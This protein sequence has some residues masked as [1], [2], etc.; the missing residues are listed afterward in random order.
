MENTNK[1]ESL[2]SFLSLYISIFLRIYTYILF[3]N[4]I[5]KK[6]NA[7]QK[8]LK[9]LRILSVLILLP[10]FTNC[11]L[12]DSNTPSTEKINS[13]QSRA[14]NNYN[15][16]LF[17]QP[18]SPLVNGTIFQTELQLNTDATSNAITLPFAFS[19]YGE[20]MSTVYLSNNGFIGFG[21]APNRTT[22]YNAISSSETLAKYLISFSNQITAWNGE[23]SQP[24]ISYGQNFLGDMVFQFKDVSIQTAPQ[25]RMTFQFIL[26]SNGSTVQIVFG[27][28]CTGQDQISNTSPRIFE[29]GLRGL[30][31]APS[32]NPT[33]IFKQT[34]AGGYHNRLLISGNWNTLSNV[35]AGTQPSSG[36]S[37]RTGV[38]MPPTVYSNT[39]IMPNTGLTYQWSL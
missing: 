12:N 11:S 24:E 3:H 15:F 18:Y 34:V 14:V 6:I 26:K 30:Q 32:W 23:G 27:P 29:V 22:I 39:V 2:G 7:M 37:V 17:N 38:N 16:T 1:K 25:V 10:F 8:L 21:S 5:I 28:N 19:M 13:A 20:A 31:F 36:M 9:T 35:K 4:K 33:T